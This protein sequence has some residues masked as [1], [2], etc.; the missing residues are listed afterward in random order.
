MVQIGLNM[1]PR[2][3]QILGWAKSFTCKLTA[4]EM[5]YDDSDLLGAMSLLWALVKAYLPQEI[6]KPVQDRL[7]EGFPTMAT[8]NIPEGY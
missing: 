3:A 7:D 2:H 4:E 5:F 1:G 6:I 8:Q